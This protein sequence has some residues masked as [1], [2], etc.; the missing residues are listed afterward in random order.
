MAVVKSFLFKK[1]KITKLYR[2]VHTLI[3]LANTHETV[4]SEAAH[5]H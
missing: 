3:R 4:I 5:C 2:E 1:Q